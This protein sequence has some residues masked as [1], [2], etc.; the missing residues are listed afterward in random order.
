MHIAQE[1]AKQ[2]H[3]WQTQVLFFVVLSL[4]VLS[5]YYGN[6][7]RCVSTH[8]IK[9]ANQQADRT[10]E[11]M[12]FFSPFCLIFFAV[13]LGC[14]SF[15]CYL[16]IDSF[17]TLPL[18]DSFQ[19]FLAIAAVFFLFFASHACIRYFVSFVFDYQ[20]YV[21]MNAAWNAYFN[22]LIIWILPILFV[23]IYNQHR[24]EWLIYL[25]IIC[26]GI[27][28]LLRLVLIFYSHKKEILSGIPYFILYL[29][30]FE[31][32]PIALVIKLTL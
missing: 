15:I 31:I 11:N 13:K 29:C 19:S 28:L 1:I 22:N 7:L 6:K 4:A 32:T 30:I 25:L 5:F 16:I 27:L 17:S 18:S 9:K 20:E 21:K 23:V 3:V 2:E 26:T 10:K 14:V 8:F 24:Y 12:G